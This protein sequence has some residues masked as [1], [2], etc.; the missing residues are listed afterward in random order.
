LKAAVWQSPSDLGD[1][2]QRLSALNGALAAAEQLDLLLCPE[3]YQCS[4]NAG[5]LI[6]DRAEALDGPFAAGVATLA[7]RHSTAVAYG[8]AERADGL[9]YNSAACFGP[10]GTLIGHR[11][12]CVLPP[13]PEQDLFRPGDGGVSLFRLGDAMIALVICYEIEFP[14]SARSAALAGADILLAPTAISKNWPIV[15]E[16]V[17]PTRAWENGLFLLYANHAGEENGLSYV[18]QSCVCAPYGEVLARAG[19]G[20]EFIT[21]EMDLARVASARNRLPF[22]KDAAALK[23]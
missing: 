17:I 16:K 20:P 15:P 6:A 1:P 12:K 10:D 8:F 18:G 22:L 3:L 23:V 19:C 4:Y 13:G 21:A 11:R 7:R 14:E 9:P 2:D 5:H